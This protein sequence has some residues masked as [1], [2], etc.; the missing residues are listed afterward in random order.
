MLFIHFQ[1]GNG[2]AESAD[3]LYKVEGISVSTKPLMHSS[4]YQLS[5]S[6][7]CVLVDTAL[8]SE[9]RAKKKHFTLDTYTVKGEQILCI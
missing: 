5:L 3:N 8:N 1:M 4:I 7:F 2:H 9:T 6:V